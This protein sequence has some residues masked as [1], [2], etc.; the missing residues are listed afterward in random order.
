MTI[1]KMYTKKYL[2]FL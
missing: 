1:S 2:N